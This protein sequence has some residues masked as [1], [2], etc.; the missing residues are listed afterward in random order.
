MLTLGGA[1]IMGFRVHGVGSQTACVT[2]SKE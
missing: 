1:L 2:S